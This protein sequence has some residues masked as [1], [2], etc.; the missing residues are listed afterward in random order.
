MS[1][2]VFGVIR[3]PVRPNIRLVSTVCLVAGLMFSAVVVHL[4]GVIIEICSI[5]SVVG[6]V[7][8]GPVVKLLLGMRFTRYFFHSFLLSE[9]KKTT[10]FVL[11]VVTITLKL[12]LHAPKQSR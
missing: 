2:I 9:P 1:I 6:I 4:I 5:S 10:H 8:I 11:C 12:V 3:C 7:L